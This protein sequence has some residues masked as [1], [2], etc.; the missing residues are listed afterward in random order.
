MIC[1]FG[2][3]FRKPEPAQDAFLDDDDIVNDEASG[4]PKE[5][6]GDEGGVSDDLRREAC[7]AGNTRA[8]SLL[9][10]QRDAATA[11]F[12]KWRGRCATPVLVSS[13]ALH[14]D[15]SDWE[16]PCGYYVFEDHGV[17]VMCLVLDM[18]AGTR[19]SSATTSSRTHKSST[20][21]TG[22]AGLCVG[23][24]QQAYRSL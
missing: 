24:V 14:L 10:C 16:L 7:N 5:D 17:Q 22:H 11:P 13:L 18:M 3:F 12:S 21:S 2:S 19:P 8:P 15:G 23:A 1:F 20:T 6:L 4:A 9:S